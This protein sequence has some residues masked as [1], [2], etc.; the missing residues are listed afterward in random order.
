VRLQLF[1]IASRWSLTFEESSVVEEAFV[2]LPGCSGVGGGSL[3]TA[4]R[5]LLPTP[6]GPEASRHPYA[7]HA[8][9]QRVKIK[10]VAIRGAVR[11]VLSAGAPKGLRARPTYRA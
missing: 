11:A 10:P 2:P 1:Y 7:M 5:G 9:V 6:V 3:D 4:R 8:V